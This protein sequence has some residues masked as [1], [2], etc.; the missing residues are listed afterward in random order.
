MTITLTARDLDLLETLTRRVRLL[1]VRQIAV[2]WWPDARSQCQTRRRIERLAAAR[3][4]EV[5]R[6]NAHP[7]LPITK[8]L[9]TWKPGD[10]EPN[11][12]RIAVTCQDRWTQPAMSM[13]VCVAA[14]LAANLFGSTACSIPLREH[15]NHDLRLACVYATYRSQRP[16]LAALWTGEHALPKAGYRIKDP[17]AF[18]CAA[19][20]Q[21]VRVIE[22]AGRYSVAQVESFHEH[23]AEHDLP[24][25]LW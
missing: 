13:T 11:C 22:S 21:V 20:G 23:C 25:E 7:L 1:T 24:Y 9:F 14:P 16:Q 18:L 5:H 4:V 19:D 2:H 12:E 8:P 6:I 10:D 17:D 15:R 3:L